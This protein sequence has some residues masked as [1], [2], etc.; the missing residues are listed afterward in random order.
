MAQ[1]SR[2]TRNWILMVAVLVFIVFLRVTTSRAIEPTGYF[3]GPKPMVIAHRGGSA[4][5]PGNTLLAFEHALDLGVDVLEM[6]VRLSRD[7]V[8][9]VIHDATVER[10]TNGQGAVA[11]LTTA[12]LQVLDAGYHWPFEGE[13]QYRGMGLRIP[14][15]AQVVARFPGQRLNLELKAAGEAAA[16]AA[17]RVLL[18]HDAQDRVLVAAF[19]TDGLLA[20]RRACPEAATSASA[21]EAL[22]FYIYQRLGLER[23]Y[24]PAAHALQLPPQARGVS[25][26]EAE[27]FTAAASRG[28]HVDIWTVNEPSA[29]RRLIDGGVGGII[30]DRPDVLLDVLGR[31]RS[32]Y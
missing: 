25:L 21:D 31:A 8:P 16:R 18:D 26:T 29:M 32:A 3:A 7:G 12:Q 14:T 17:C 10:T 11:A 23:M 30:T 1:V 19:D 28:M 13:A 6:D 5:R 24:H 15:L 2:R 9:V 27:L 22:W 4:L 20:F